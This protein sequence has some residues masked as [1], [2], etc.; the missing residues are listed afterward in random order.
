MLGGYFL[1]RWQM[2]RA[3]HG[4]R[5]IDTWLIIGVVSLVAGAHLGHVVF[6][7]WSYYMAHP[8][9]IVVFKGRGLSSHGAAIGVMVGM[10]VYSRIFRIPVLEVFDANTF[11]AGL[12]ATLVRLG[13]FFNHEIVGRVTTLP[14]AIR[15]KYYY[16]QGAEPRHPSQLYEF[17][18]GLIV[19]TVLFLVDRHYGARRPKGVLTG[20]FAVVYFSGR[21]FVEFLF[22]DHGP[23]PLHSLYSCWYHYIILRFAQGPELS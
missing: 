5:E 17:C 7:N 16:D 6:Y 1:W 22:P 19:L 21:F 20:V 15:F 10:L 13:N 12:A 4:V 14:W 9:E 11:S 3:G 18:L 23:V 8:L 2:S